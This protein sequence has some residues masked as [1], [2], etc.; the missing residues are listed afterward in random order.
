[1]SIGS[2]ISAAELIKTI[3]HRNGD[4]ALSK[5][6]LY[7][8]YITTVYNELRIDITN[9]S[10]IKKLYI[11]KATNSLPIPNDCM[12]LQAV[13][14]LNEEN[15][16]TPLWYNDKI[17]LNLLFSNTKDCSCDTC[18]GE[19]TYCGVIGSIDEVSEEVTINDEV[20]IKYVK[21]TTLIDGTVIVTSK[22]PTLV[23]NEGVETV[24]IVNTQ[25][26]LCK[27]DLLPC[28]CVANTPSNV[29]SISS[30]NCYCSDMDTNC[31]TY[32]RYIPKDKGY[33]LD[34]NEEQIIF[35][36]T[37]PYNYAVLRYVTNIN[38]AKDYRIPLIAMEAMIYGIMYY[39]NKF[40]KTATINDRALGGTWYNDYQAEKKKLSKRIN[41]NNYAK[42]MGSMGVTSEK[43]IYKNKKH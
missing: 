31:G 5:A 3:C 41:P 12:I 26:E 27:I 43:S 21:T 28:G 40:S 4:L 25:E 24:E 6:H 20:Y 8:T 23:N 1:M 9:K 42:I 19:H 33:R 32:N 22:I 36:R 38:S 13:G 17:P 35:D 7:E 2:Y 10:V 37:Y 11:N 34:M 30:M 15:V 14:Y 29:E 39:S 18:G 16:V